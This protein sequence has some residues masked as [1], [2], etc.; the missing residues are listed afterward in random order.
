L[1]VGEELYFVSDKGI[2][3]CVDARTGDLHWTERLGGNFSASPIFANRRIL[4]LNETGEA[5]WV[6]PGKQFAI[7][8]RNEL[9]G[10]TLATPAFAGGAMYLRTDEHLYKFAE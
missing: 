10:R 7:L 2:A 8:G 3:S 4:F 1:L 9:P 6:Q 5:T